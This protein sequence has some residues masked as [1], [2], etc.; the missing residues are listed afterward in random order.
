MSVIINPLNAYDVIQ[1]L[2]FKPSDTPSA[3]TGRWPTHED[4]KFIDEVGGRRRRAFEDSIDSPS[5][6][7][8]LSESLQSMK[9][10]PGVLSISYGPTFVPD[11]SVDRSRGWNYNIAVKLKN[12]SA[13]ESYA[14]HE[15]HISVKKDNILPLLNSGP[16]EDVM[17]VDW[18]DEGTGLG[19]GLDEL[20]VNEK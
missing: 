13:L 15:Q 1:S 2:V 9:S 11:G 16:A 8:S 12:K 14:T 6:L 18:D 17:A 4:T 19:S 7:L 5:S 3:R 20:G 10:I